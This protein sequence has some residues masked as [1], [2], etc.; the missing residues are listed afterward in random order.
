MK[1]SPLSPS[2]P[3]PFYL[4]DKDTVRLLDKFVFNQIK[5]IPHPMR[6]NIIKKD[7]PNNLECFLKLYNQNFPDRFEVA[8]SNYLIA[9][10]EVTILYNAVFLIIR[11]LT[12]DSI[13]MESFTTRRML[14]YGVLD[15]STDDIMKYLDDSPIKFHLFAFLY[16][17]IFKGLELTESKREILNHRLGYSDKYV[18]LTGTEMSDWLS[19]TSEAVYQSEQSL[20]R[21]IKDVIKVFK[22]FSPFYSY[23]SKYLSGKD[24]VKVSPAVFDC[25]RREDGVKEMT[26]TFIAKVLSEI[27]NYAIDDEYSRVN[28]DYLLIYKGD[29]KN[30]IIRFGN[31]E[32]ER[33]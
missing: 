26:D 25:I 16:D 31:Q 8:A 18:T 33:N 20:E 5:L 19:I 23:K 3:A 15:A 30:T 24:K 27:Y 29:T 10:K 4:I 11:A 1:S 17:I 14:I 22:V 13:S 28:E 9:Y 6:F 7:N 21:D 2:Y 32:A 12:S